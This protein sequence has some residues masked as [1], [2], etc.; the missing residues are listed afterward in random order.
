MKRLMASLAVCVVGGLWAG[1]FV[2]MSYN[3]SASTDLGV[4]LWAWPLVL[5]YDGDGDL[6][7]VVS[8]PCVPSRGDWFFENPGKDSKDPFPVFNAGKK[9]GPGSGNI[10]VS[11]VQGGKP[12]VLTPGSANWNPF[13][14]GTAA[15]AFKGLKA[16]IHSANV[17]GNVWRLVDWDG[18]G[19]DDLLVGV[20]DYTSYGWDNAYDAQGN[21][22]KGPLNG[23]VYVC[24]NLKGEGP[25]AEY[26]P[27][28]RVTL[29]DGS[30][31]HTFG[32]PMPMAADWDGDGDLDLI[33]GSFMDDFTYF[34]NIG[35]RTS[36]S[37]AQGRKLTTA[38]GKRLHMDL[39]MITP[40]A[41]D[42]DRDGDLD[43]ICGD[44][45]GRV[46][47]IENKGASKAG[48]P[49]VF[50]APR[51]FRQ[52]MDSLKFG[53]LATPVAVDWDGD[54]DE[55][56]IC[57]NSAGYLAFIENKSG[58][59]VSRP[60]WGK[61][62]LFSF[63]GKDWPI[64]Q[65]KN[66]F[67]KANPIRIQAGENGS[68]QGP[69]EAKWGYT[70]VSVADWDG[71]GFKDL[72]VNGITGDVLWLRN[73]GRAGALELESPR[74]VEVEW[75]GAQ[76]A[77]KWGFRRPQGKAL[78]TQWRTTPLALD[79]TGDGLV[80]L[81][82]LDAEGYLCLFERARVNGKL[83]LKAPR[84][85][86]CWK[87]GTPMRLNAKAAGGSGRRKL[88]ATDWDGDGRLDLIVNGQNADLLR[89]V[90]AKDGTWRFENCGALGK[91]RLAGHTTAPTACDFDGNGV[92]DLLVGAEDGFFYFL[93]N[94]R[95]A[96]PVKDN[97]IVLDNG[98]VRRVLSTANGRL[99]TTSYRFLDK[100]NREYLNTRARVSEF[101]V[102]INDCF[103]RGNNTWKDVATTTRTLANGG[104]Q[105]TV[106][107]TEPTGAFQLALTY[108]LYP[109]LP[110]IR[111]TLAVTNLG[112]GD[113]KV[114]AVN[115]EDIPLA[116]GCTSSVTFRQYGR[117]RAQGP[118][119]GDWNDPLV[120]IHNQSALNGIAV[121]NET[122]GVLKH[123]KTF[124]NGNVLHVGTTF[125]DQPYPFRTWLAAGRTWTS[126]AVF[127]APYDQT[128]NPQKVVNTTVQTYWRKYMGTRIEQIPHK[129]MFVYNTWV[130]F[131]RNINEQ[132]IRELAKAAAECGIEEFVIDDGWQVNFDSPKGRPDYRG[133]W[134]VDPKKFPN[135]LRP[136]FDY[137][138]S[139]GMKPGLWVSLALADRSSH[140]YR[141]HPEWMTLDPSGKPANLHGGGLDSS[142][143][144][145]GTDW[146][147]YIREKILTLVR[148]HG[149]AYVK[150]DLAIATSA[151]VYDNA[152][153]GCYASHHPGHRDQASSFDIIYRRA[154]ELFDD[155]HRAAPDLFIDCTFE[156]AGKLQLMDYG[157]ARHAEGN[158]LSN[159]ETR[160][161]IGTLR[162]RG[163]AWERSPALPPTSLVIGNL[164][165][166]GED[167]IL[168][169]KSLTGTL[170]IMLGDPRQLTPDERAE[171]R[172]HA[173]WLKGLEQRHGIMS[174]RQDLP[175]FG[176]PA[177]GAW[178]G[179]AR[180]NDETKSGGLVGVF[181][182]GAMEPSRVVVV[183]ALDPAAVYRVTRAPD[184]ARVAE[185][186]GKDLATKG[187]VVTFT[188][189]YAGDLFEISRIK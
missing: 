151:Y 181:R 173:V 89:Q 45:D 147:D 32:N 84:R 71:D 185:M 91:T 154:L 99:A 88:C 176:E 8:S 17:R 20:E 130:P 93:Q 5:D 137:I 51:Y 48:Q 53:A 117:Y 46:A 159:I 3:D 59:G 39:Q 127:T 98:L 69:C 139:L 44:E 76:P 115:V 52:R 116:I 54:G 148:E 189:L 184:G 165:M 16:N 141:E 142:T 21:W 92:P 111:K 162:M 13:D 153:S 77:Q 170:P 164:H 68:I 66:G 35:T 129:P 47:F 42:W 75:T 34:E 22:V 180:L 118:Y 23:F 110:L 24:R 57:G 157:F 63:T 177:E 143:A 87:D 9:I 186:S 36:P 123:T 161:P 128:N 182:Q 126:D 171:Y 6:D 86:F 107:L 156:T 150:L 124:Q 169:W 136:V 83:V 146:T 90:E 74:P 14:R 106:T 133:D 18:D 188:Q 168:S 113:L 65:T 58:A 78:L 135:G 174:F 49:P 109:D 55:D 105:T 85:A 166:N 26:A 82:M 60:R 94:P 12:V 167:H 155:L 158:W 160:P 101:A 112:T 7:L 2:R 62:V 131:R 96:A 138:K 121:G 100:S 108:T 178:D 104:R 11:Y 163:Y 67:V 120:I 140:P 152:R 102:M 25:N 30:P 122:P 50:A 19:R 183:P 10:A 145:L 73:P 103:Y 37:F 79:W 43:L 15:T 114:E 179:F 81:V 61:P 97:T 95:A 33:C 1:D 149:L 125:P 172:R 187:F 28:V 27:A 80:D 132:N 29:K 64:P 31:L 72:L 70:V 38:D 134:T 119:D 4:G 41:V 175:G 144:C 56:L 40:S